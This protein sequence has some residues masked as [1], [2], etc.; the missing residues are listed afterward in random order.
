MQQRVL[1]DL[2]GDLHQGAAVALEIRAAGETL[3]RTRGRL[4]PQGELSQA[5]QTWRSRYQQLWFPFRLGEPAEQPRYSAPRDLAAALNTAATDLSRA[6]NAWL[7]AEDFRP[8][9]EK[10]LE[11]LAPSDEIQLHLQVEDAAIRRLPW[12]RWDFFERYPLAE[13][14]LSAPAYE[15]IVGQPSPRSRPRLLAVLGHRSGIDVERDRQ[16]LQ[17]I[18]QLDS[19]FLSEPSRAEL[20][21]QLWDATGWDL[22]FFAGHSRSLADG[23]S[24][25]LELNDRDS[26]APRDLDR[27]LSHAVRCGLQV[28][29]FNSC[30][31][32]GLAR[33]LESLQIPQIVVMREPVPDRVAQDF[34]QHLLRALAGGRSLYLAV[35]EARERLQVLEDQCPCATWLPAI[36]HNPSTPLYQFPAPPPAAPPPCPYQGL[37]AFTAA[38]AAVFC[39]REAAIAH[40]LRAVEQKPLLALVG[41]SGS[42]KSSL[43]AAGLLP[44]LPEGAIARPI[45]PGAQPFAAL[46]AALAERLEPDAGATERLLASQPLARALANRELSLADLAE[47]LLQQEGGDRLVLVVDQLEE[48]FALCEPELGQTFLACLLADLD[49]TPHYRLIVAL[50]ADFFAAALAAR[51][52]AEA[53]ARYQPELLQPMRRDELR[54][55][56]EQPAAIAGLKLAPGLTERLLEAVG[57]APGN[58]PLLEFTLTALWERQEQGQ[59]THAAYDDLGGVSQA[60]AGYAER[61]YQALSLTEQQ[62]ARRIF[63]QLVHPGDSTADTRRVAQQSE[64]GAPEVVA[65]LAAA[66]LVVLADERAEIVH[67]ALIQTWPRLQDWLAA[68]R[69]FRAWQERLRLALRE[70]DKQR[71]DP[72]RLLQ[73]TPLLEAARWQSEQPGELSDR[74][75]EFIQTSLAAWE[76]HQQRQ[77]A[78][79]RRA[80][81]ALSAGLVASLSLAGAALWQWRQ[82]ELGRVSEQLA[83]LSSSSEQLLASHKELEALLEAIRGAQRL[84]D[85]RAARPEARVRAIAALH[86]AIYRTREFNRLEGHPRTVIS[87]AFSPKGDYLASAGDDQTVRL[88]R[89]DGQL[90]ATLQEHR[91]LVKSVAWSPDG[92]ILASGSHDGTVRL[93]NLDGEL[94]ATLADAPGQINSV[95][96]SPDGQHLAAA[97]SSGR[98]TLWREDGSWLRSF[99]AHRSWVQAVA[100]SPDGDRLATASSDRTAKLWTPEGQW[101]ATLG[102]YDGAANSVAFSPDGQWLAT[103]GNDGWLR[104]WRARDGAAAASWLAHAQ[105][106]WGVQFSPDSQTVATASA[107]NAVQLWNLDGTAIAAF[108]GHN[109]SVYGL[110]FSPD[111]QVLATASADTTIRFWNPQPRPL[112]RW[113]QAAELRDAAFSPDGRWLATAAVD[114][115]VM[116]RSPAG[117]QDRLLA[118][119]PAPVWQLAWRPDGLVLAIASAA[120]TELQTPEGRRLQQLPG[121]LGAAFSP[122]GRLL[123]TAGR[124]RNVQ[125]WGADGTLQQTLLG[126]Q[127]PVLGVRFS[128]DGRWLAT[129][130][131]DDTVKLWRRQGGDR[132][133]SEPLTLTGHSSRVSRAAWSP[134]GQLLATASDDGTVRLWRR[135]AWGGFS[136]H[137]DKTLQ[138]H[139]DKVRDVAFSPDGKF[140]ASASDDGMVKLWTPDGALLAALPGHA[141]G[142]W[143]L[144]FR[145]D[146]RLLASASADGTAIVWN[147]DLADLLAKGC[148]DVRDYL[149]TNATLS[150]GDRQLCDRRY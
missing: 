134:D 116:L 11:K 72:G 121:S 14:A 81:A 125:L 119:A 6:L 30:D 38:E 106:I 78:W 94:L 97:D 19:V 82:A 87:A 142:V 115:E 148:A 64:L 74:E 110:S 147:L 138:G 126:H 101:V 102:E 137:P 12:H 48:L 86:Q 85:V 1:L 35:R 47:G 39:G 135:R 29:I 71:D 113:P 80:I 33:Q 122:D 52:L 140:L 117:Q 24:G 92:T 60:L 61:T 88:W 139:A 112:A 100:W 3:A 144:S 26:L 15:R 57:E 67:E 13:P 66:R 21:A 45:R 131:D 145:A 91:D 149:R 75:R 127:G 50:R 34:L 79:Q 84:S 10:L 49:A 133:S 2:D 8:V 65:R 36:C 56:I 32:L 5:Y 28:A 20:D 108:Q 51:P 40:L 93:W 95:A 109:A 76:R 46:A 44:R 104:L 16:L 90:L 53:I 42:G 124:G 59:L 123:A 96:W 25:S 132:F 27:A 73:G 43:L 31:G 54:A 150:P 136:T 129:T 114:G 23:S 55:A 77:R 22:F 99:R 98:V 111:G 69:Q 68:A 17:Q 58:L 9:R 18:P 62:Q 130:S 4:P 146:G 141:A 128:P 41:A 37:A 7:R 107:D 63:T 118:T 143:G 120:A 105:R 103:A 70:W 83:A 89:R